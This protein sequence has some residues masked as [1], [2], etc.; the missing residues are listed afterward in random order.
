MQEEIDVEVDKQIRNNPHNKSR[1]KSSTM[2]ILPQ[3]KY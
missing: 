1:C 2:I 3:D